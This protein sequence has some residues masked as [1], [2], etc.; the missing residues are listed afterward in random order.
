MNLA[1]DNLG[2]DVLPK[3]IDAVRPLGVV[4]VYGFVAGTM[5]PF[6]IRNFFFAQKQLHGSMASDISDLKWGLEQVGAGRIK[7]TLDRTFSLKETAE[8]YRTSARNQVMGNIAIL[9]WTA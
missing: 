9:P 8:A 7:P 1:I 6:D 4:V 3:T 5:T 2:G